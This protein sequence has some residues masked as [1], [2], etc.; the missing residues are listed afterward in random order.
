MPWDM[1]ET[2]MKF[3]K[4]VKPA[5]NNN[6]MADP[7]H[8]LPEMKFLETF[9]TTNLFAGRQAPMIRCWRLFTEVRSEAGNANT[10]ATSSPTRGQCSIAFKRFSN[11]ILT[12]GNEYMPFTDKPGSCCP[13]LPVLLNY[14]DIAH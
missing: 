11:I 2:F 13:S 10:V 4:L 14:P 5:P 12:P 3:S 9:P 1:L 7:P 6:E 8:Y